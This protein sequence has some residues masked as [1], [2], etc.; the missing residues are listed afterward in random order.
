M[1]KFSKLQLD[2]DGKPYDTDIREIPQ[3]AMVGCPHCIM[4]QEHYRMDNTCRCD[5]P[6]HDEMI[7][8]GYVWDGDRWIAPDQGDD[9]SKETYYVDPDSYP[10]DFDDTKP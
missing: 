9:D 6:T 8:W 7:A 2:A 1:V 10:A 3:S 4:M 5:D